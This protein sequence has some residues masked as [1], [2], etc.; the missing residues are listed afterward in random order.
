MMRGCQA[1]TVT[2]CFLTSSVS[3]GLAETD[4]RTQSNL[5]ADP[6]QSDMHLLVPIRLRD[7]LFPA[8]FKRERAHRKQ[9]KR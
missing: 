1:P 5:T 9:M 2:V 6:I 7:G 8:G 3:C 4:R